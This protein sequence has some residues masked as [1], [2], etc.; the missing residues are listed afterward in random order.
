MR[1]NK[2]PDSTRRTTSRTGR[3]K[4]NT[5]SIGSSNTDGI[6]VA[7]DWARLMWLEREVEVTEPPPLESPILRD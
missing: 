3:N 2:Q 1:S 7:S 5:F 4:Y 6:R